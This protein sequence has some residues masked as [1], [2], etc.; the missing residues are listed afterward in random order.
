M[1]FFVR[2]VVGDLGVDHLYQV[3]RLGVV[4]ELRGEAD[5]GAGV[6]VGAREQLGAELRL[7]GVDGD[8]LEVVA[9]GLVAELLHVGAGGVG[10]EVGV[11]DEAREVIEGVG[12]HGLGF[13]GFGPRWRA[14]S[15]AV[16]ASKQ[17]ASYVRLY[18]NY[19]RTYKQYYRDKTILIGWKDT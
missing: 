3:L 14:R 16:V 10:V 6:D 19:V 2:E 8:H 4:L 9:L 1:G 7:D 13:L 11:V 5:R 12:L 17:W 18:C 15:A